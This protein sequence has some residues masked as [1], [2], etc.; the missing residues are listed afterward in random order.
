MSSLVSVV[1]DFQVAMIHVYSFM[2]FTLLPN[3]TF[4]S[5]P[6]CLES[7][8]LCRTVMRTGMPVSMEEQWS[9]PGYRTYSVSVSSDAFSASQTS[10]KSCLE[11][12]CRP[13]ELK[14]IRRL[15]SQRQHKTNH[16]SKSCT[17]SMLKHPTLFAFPV[18]ISDRSGLF[19]K[20][21][22]LHMS[23]LGSAYPSAVCCIRGWLK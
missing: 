19:S 17:S 15:G 8:P 14:F 4:A 11:A 18:T 12:R 3:S 1:R 16:S 5:V 7:L 21:E 6:I 9:L 10:K 20:R 23:D 13:L 22:F 2:K